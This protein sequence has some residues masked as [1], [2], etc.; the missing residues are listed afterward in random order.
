MRLE[1]KV[2]IVTGAARGIGLA[3]AKRFADEG[4]AVVLADVNAEGGEAAADAITAGGGKA[5]FVGCDVG[6]G[7]Q[8]TALAESAVSTY[9]GLDVCVCN[10]GIIHAADFLDLEEEDFDRVIRTNLKGSF[11][12]GQAAAR[13]MVKAGTAGSIIHM[14]SVNGVMAIPNQTPYNVSKGGINQLTRVMALALA[15][16][17]I[18][19]NAIGPG[20]ILTE[21]A[22]TILTDDAARRMI[23]S[24]TPMGRL[25]DVDEVARIAVFLATEDSSYITGQIIFC[26]GGRMALN[27]VVPVEE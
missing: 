14:S 18:R 21:M 24:R 9:G 6:N 7:A 10:A 12:V 27:Y 1:N 11:L 25:G 5:I 8:A 15:D 26:D 19:V 23:F 3:I 2:A 16:K 4:A 20:T 22:Q 17:K 13:E